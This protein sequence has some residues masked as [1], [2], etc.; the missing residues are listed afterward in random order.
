VTSLPLIRSVTWRRHLCPWMYIRRRLAALA[1]FLVQFNA[2]P[3][4]AR[5]G[6]YPLFSPEPAGRRPLPTTSLPVSHPLSVA[7]SEYSR[8]YLDKKY[9]YT[10]LAC[11]YRQKIH[12]IH[13]LS[14][15]SVFLTRLVT[16]SRTYT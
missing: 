16:R 15:K 3:D 2:R 6:T 14:D 1:S 5:H 8:R 11:V 4:S 7:T 9:N 12:I 10:S 13:K